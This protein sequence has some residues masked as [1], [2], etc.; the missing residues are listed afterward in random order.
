VA[1]SLIQ[2]GLK[3]HVIAPEEIPM[4]RFLGPGVGRFVK[5]LH[6][7]HAVQFHLGHTAI[8]F[9]GA[10]LTLDD[11]T[12]LKVDFIV[13][14]VGV[15]PRTEL[16]DRS[17]LTVENGIVVDQYLETDVPGIFAAGD[18]ANYVAP[19]GERMRVEHWV[20]A[21]RQGQTAARNMLGQ[22]QAFAEVPFFWSRHFTTSILYVG[23][24]TE[25]DE[26][27]VSGSISAGD[28]CVRLRRDGRTEAVVTIGRPMES[29]VEEARLQSEL[30]QFASPDERRVCASIPGH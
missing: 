25:W 22:R 19:N 5:N 6:E 21:Q 3:V 4:A 20:V 18:V 11:E 14:G 29:M 28:C 15:R 17:G 13:V 7:E 23:H 24:A 27:S 2:R 12:S 26:T 8:D 16:A 1:A 30:L 9:D 10:C